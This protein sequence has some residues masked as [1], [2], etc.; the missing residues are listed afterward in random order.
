M[1]GIQYIMN[2]AQPKASAPARGKKNKSSKKNT[3]R[4][5]L[6]ENLNVRPSSTFNT[7]SDMSQSVSAPV[8]TGIVRRIN[9]PAQKG[10]ANGDLMVRHREYVQDIN[11]SIAFAANSFSV[12]PGLPGLFPWLSGVAQRFESYRFRKLKFDFETE[13]PTSATGTALLS[14]DY[15]ASDASPTSKTQAMAYRS[16]V[17][18]P[19]WSNCQ[20]TCLQEDLNK[21]TSFFVRK[22][23]APT[24]TD[25]KLYDVGN[26]NVC[27]MGQANGNNIGELYVEYEITLMT[28]QLGVA[29]QGE[30]VWGAFTGTSNSAPFST[31]TGILPAT[32]ISTGTTTSTTTWTF[33]QP[34]QGLVASTV[35]GTGLTAGVTYGGSATVGA[36]SS[37]VNSGG[38]QL[39]SYGLVNA[40]AGQTFGFI[41]PNTTVTTS[42]IDFAQSG[43]SF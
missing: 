39:T 37:T 32:F 34:W 10:L 9:N 31:V 1:T 25:I 38:T 19:V 28:P 4:K 16:S 33:T 24:G 30:A 2:K 42:S 17:R 27:T 41:F 3:L 20:L 7:G 29:G 6:A 43:T 22:G 5:I 23:A 26:L 14:L 8:S 13:S 40:A 35:V 11:G 15:D 36:I 18:S 21:R 12:N